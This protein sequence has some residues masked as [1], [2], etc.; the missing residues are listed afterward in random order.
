ME[1]KSAFSNQRLIRERFTCDGQN[2]S[3]PMAWEGVPKNIRSFALVCDDPDAPGGVWY[4]WAIFDIPASERQL[5]EHQ[6]RKDLMGKFRQAKNSFQK[7]GYDG[8]CP[9][10]GHGVHHYR[11]RL[12]A[13]PIDRLPTSSNPTC[14]EVLDAA[15]HRALDIALL[16]GTYQR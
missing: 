10:P 3:P 13:L 5:A 16:T 11:F 6:P 9:P 2:L 1:L 4:H 15:Q 12:L 7:I 14:A 8:P